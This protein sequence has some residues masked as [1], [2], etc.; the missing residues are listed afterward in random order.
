M[1][2]KIDFS[3]AQRTD[4]LQSVTKKIGLS[5]YCGRNCIDEDNKCVMECWIRKSFDDRVKEWFPSKNGNLIVKLDDDNGVDDNVKAKS[6]NTMP[7]HF[8]RK[9]LSH[10]KRLMD[11]VIKKRGGFL[12]IVFTT[13]IPILCIY[14]GITGLIWLIMDSL[15]NILA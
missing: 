3:K 12:V 9:I 7:S 5:V 11:D 15:V 8:G 10:S 2:D 14:I 6:V 4:I 1:F 13:P